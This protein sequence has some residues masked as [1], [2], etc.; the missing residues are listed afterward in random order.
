MSGAEGAPAYAHIAMGP[1]GA[2]WWAGEVCRK[3][4]VRGAHPRDYPYH[5][6]Y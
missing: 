3:G 2:P 1:D 6:R 5:A 4:T